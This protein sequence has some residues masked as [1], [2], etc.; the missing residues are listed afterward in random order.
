MYDF[1]I[2]VV[3][4]LFVRLGIIDAP[5][6]WLARPDTALYS[7]IVAL[8][9]QGFPFFTVVILAG[10]QTIPDE[11]YEAAEI[12]GASRWQQLRSVI[13]PVDRRHR[14]DRAAAAH[15]L[16]RQFARRDPGHDRRRPR[17]RHA[18]LAAL[19]LREGLQ[20]DGVRLCGGAC[21]HP[22]GSSAR[23]GLHLCA[24]RRRGSQ[25]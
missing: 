9:W 21:G 23:R 24:P 22:D 16:G 7:I 13:L 2:G 20:L 8:I 14:H 11:L 5:I 25:Q 1:H 12:D 6:A 19:R 10:L 3:N 4:D 17:I 18:H 15:H